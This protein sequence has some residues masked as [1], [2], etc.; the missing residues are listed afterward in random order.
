MK[1]TNERSIGDL[2]GFGDSVIHELGEEALTYY[3]NGKA[4]MKFDEALVT[5]A[6]L[7]LAEA[8]QEK[9]IE[10]FPDH[11]IFGNGNGEKEYSHNSQR[12]LWVFDPLDGV[13]NFQAGIPV[14]AMSISLYEN[15]WPIF[16]MIYMPATGDLFSAQ[17]GKKAC[18]GKNRIEVSSQGDI[19]DESLLLT[20]SRFHRHYRTS[21][22]GKVRDFG[23]S[24]AHICFVAMGRADAAILGNESFHGLA[25]ARVILE[26]SGGR[27]YY[28]NGG[29]IHLNEYLDGGKVEGHILAC[30]PDSV[31]QINESLVEL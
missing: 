28:V 29:E 15:F 12:Y 24:S 21:F 26:A 1:D 22:P 20:F 13:A 5:E 7:S 16:G 27:L 2:V 23:C 10:K 30:P 8:F 9:L 31:T 25:A 4:Q 6:E 18:I 11:Q 19:D 3:G 17:P 14:W